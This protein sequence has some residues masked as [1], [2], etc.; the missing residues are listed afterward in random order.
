MPYKQDGYTISSSVGSFNNSNG[1]TSSSFVVSD[2]GTYSF[3]ADG[4][5]LNPTFMVTIEEP[6][7]KLE[8]PVQKKYGVLYNGKYQIFEPEGFDENTMDI[9]Y[10]VKKELGQYTA[11]VR[12]K[13]VWNSIWSDGTTE[14]VEYS[15]EIIQPGIMLKESANID[16]IYKDSN[17]QRRGYKEDNILIGK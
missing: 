5:Y 15:F 8:K 11:L 10:N 1:E 16:Y 4:T 9:S 12:L 7:A 6:I 17:N 2:A 3:Y 14:S 13:N